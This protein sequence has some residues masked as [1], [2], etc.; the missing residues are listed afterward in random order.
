[1]VDRPVMR[2]LREN[3]MWAF[4]GNV[5]FSMCQWLVLIAVAKL[6]S[7]AAAGDWSLGLAVTGPIFVFAQ[8]K[9]RAVQTTDAR[10]EYGWADYAAVRALG[11]GGAMLATAAVVL[12]AYRDR[13]APIILLAGLA[14]VF[15]ALS[16]LGYGEQQRNERLDLIA[17]S[18]IRR[19]LSSAAAAALTMWLTD[20]VVLVTASTALVYAL[21]WAW[22]LPAIR[23]VV[24]GRRL[25]PVWRWDRLRPLLSMVVPLGMVGAIGSLQSNIPRY[26]LD[27]YAGRAELGVWA[28]VSY[29]LVFGNMTIGAIANAALA[30]LAR[31][32]A[33]Q[34]WRAYLRLLARLLAIGMTIGVATVLGSIVLGP[35][36]LRL[37]Y[38][39][40]V[41]ANADILTLLA[42]SAGLLY[43]YL[44]L[45]TAMD[46]LR[47]YRIQPYIHVTTALVIACACAL[48]V[49][50]HG[51]H[52][53]AWAMI[54]G[55]GCECTCYVVSVT[56]VVRGRIRRSRAAGTA[57]GA[58]GPPGSA[59]A[60]QAR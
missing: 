52:G 60:E 35:P 14:K 50:G 10:G 20:D 38:S 33:E 45:G 44:F 15:D 48:L 24:A 58:A 17:A 30:R 9:L 1:M 19:G 32:A 46:G 59:G 54:A 3:M 42:I 22:D 23:A 31:H 7:T 21:W 25:R 8:F 29:L 47:S 26:F 5:V 28:A 39:D 6:G 56:I 40:E 13:T 51:A 4:A 2:S 36:A 43:S 12:I 57:V 53:A 18:Q 49:P 16:D 55:Y 11:A 41:A 27:G 34:D 37:L